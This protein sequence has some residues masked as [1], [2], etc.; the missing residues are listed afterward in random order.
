MERC[1][2]EV[3]VRRPAGIGRGKETEVSRLGKD[4]QNEKG[5]RNMFVNVIYGFAM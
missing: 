5:S 1:G 4:R 3:R 2:T